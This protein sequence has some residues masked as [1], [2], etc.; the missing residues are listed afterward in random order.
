MGGVGLTAGSGVFVVG[1]AG[2][3]SVCLQSLHRMVTLSACGRL[4]SA[5]VLAALPFTLVLIGHCLACLCF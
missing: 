1:T 3:V 2:R 5:A 4:S